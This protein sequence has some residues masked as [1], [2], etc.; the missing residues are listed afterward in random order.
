MNFTFLRQLFKIYIFLKIILNLLNSYNGPDQVH[1]VEKRVF[2]QGGRG[3]CAVYCT[4]P[5]RFIII[6][7]LKNFGDFFKVQPLIVIY[8]RGNFVFHNWVCKSI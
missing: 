4:R 6:R 2:S 7:W 8:I 5:Q 3:L 1:K